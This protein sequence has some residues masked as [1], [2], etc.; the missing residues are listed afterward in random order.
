[1][2]A[3]NALLIL[4]FSLGK[5]LSTS[6][7]RCPKLAY[8]MALKLTPLSGL[9]KVRAHVSEPAEE[10][11][12]SRGGSADD[13]P[14]GPTGVGPRPSTCTRLRVKAR[15]PLRRHLRDTRE[16]R[17]LR[18]VSS[19]KDRPLQ[20]S[21]PPYASLG[22]SVSALNALIAC[23]EPPAIIRSENERVRYPSFPSVRSSSL[24]ALG[25]SFINE[26]TPGIAAS[27]RFSFFL[28]VSHR[29]LS[30]MMISI[31]F[32]R[33]CS[34]P[35]LRFQAAQGRGRPSRVRRMASMARI[36]L[37]RA[38]STTDRISA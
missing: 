2:Q 5:G 38:V 4:S 25:I 37:R 15:T 22:P 13:D 11:Q 24:I 12:A 27:G 32:S 3:L 35:R 10:L 23:N 7:T 18:L 14:P 20:K 1:M 33:N 9:S 8:R 29:S 17:Y 36:D 31:I 16:H 26:S 21:D 34:G 19:P 6:P 30:L 28:V